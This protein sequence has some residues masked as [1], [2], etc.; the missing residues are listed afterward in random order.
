MT[1][2]AS[3]ISVR[4]GGERVRAGC[5]TAFPLLG[6]KPLAMGRKDECGISFQDPFYLRRSRQVK[7]RKVLFFFFLLLLLLY[8]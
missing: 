3:I 8:G 4:A 2:F 7:A 1:F 5:D 6:K